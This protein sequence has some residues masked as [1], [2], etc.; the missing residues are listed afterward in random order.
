MKRLA[1]LLALILAIGAGWWFGSPWW[2]LRQMQAAAEK[3]DARALSEH[4]DFAAL[5]ESLKGQLRVRFGASRAEPEMGALGAIVAS[6]LADRI[7]DAAVT[8]EGMRAIFAAAPAVADRAPR[9]LKM[10][11]SEMEM[12]RDGPTQFRMVARD[13]SGAELVFRVRGIGWQLVEVRV[14]AHA[15][16]L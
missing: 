2:T 14:P 7:V 6:G 13:G 1:V 3:G 12:R 9:P 11:V 8:P 15:A 16:L 5:R 10:R 4:I